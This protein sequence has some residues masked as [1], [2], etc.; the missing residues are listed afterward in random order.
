MMKRYWKPIVLAIALIG[1]GAAGFLATPATAAG[2]PKICCDN[3]QCYNCVQG[4][5]GR[6][7]CPDI[8][9]P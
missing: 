8:A 4:W 5:N 2:C 6:C 9:C 1:G 3:G 7:L